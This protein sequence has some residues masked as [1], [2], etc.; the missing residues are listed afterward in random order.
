M[1][2]TKK[3]IGG[4]FEIDNSDGSWVY[5]LIDVKKGELL[6]Y[7]FSNQHPHE[8]EPASYKDWRPFVPAYHLNKRW[9]KLGW[10]T[11]RRSK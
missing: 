4:L 8:I 7:T 3:D 9:V 1:K 11:G 2:L 5:Q 6:F 10:E